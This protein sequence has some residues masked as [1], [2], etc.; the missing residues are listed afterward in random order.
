MRSGRR[1]L[2]SGDI[3]LPIPAD[4]I[5]EM[6]IRHAQVRRVRRLMQSPEPRSIEPP[7][8]GNVVAIPQ[9]GGLHHEY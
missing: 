5:D 7:D 4:I 1:F 8:Q 3:N 6:I 2:R 9:V